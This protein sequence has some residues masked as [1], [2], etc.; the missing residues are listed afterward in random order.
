MATLTL[1]SSQVTFLSL[2]IIFVP[3][4]ICN[5]QAEYTTNEV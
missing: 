5:Y 4:K 1:I 2:L 3:L